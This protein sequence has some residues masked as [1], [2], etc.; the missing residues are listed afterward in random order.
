M[1]VAQPLPIGFVS[2]FFWK[3]PPLASPRLLAEVVNRVK[4]N[5]CVYI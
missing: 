3:L 1:S 2:L 4:W 5:E